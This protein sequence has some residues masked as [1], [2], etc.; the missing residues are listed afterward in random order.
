[1]AQGLDIFDQLKKSFDIKD[2]DIRTYSPLSL[3]FIGDAIYDLIIRSVVVAKG[4]TSNNRLHN[5]ATQFVSARAQARIVDKIM[6]DLSEEELMIFRRGKNAKPSSTAKNA[7]PAE[8]HKATGFEAL[9][10]YLY[11]KG[12]FERVSELTRKGMEITERNDKDE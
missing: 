7:S 6:D 10:G 4:N 11:L 5:E 2:V 3:A 8:Y 1:M 12:E 9:L